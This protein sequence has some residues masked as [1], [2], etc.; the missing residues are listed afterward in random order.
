MKLS[1]KDW[2]MIILKD[3]LYYKEINQNNTK[4]PQTEIEWLKLD[5]EII[6]DNRCKAQLKNLIKELERD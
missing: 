3:H 2:W 5:L 6:Q 4:K 1:L